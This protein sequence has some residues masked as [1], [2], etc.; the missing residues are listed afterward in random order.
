MLKLKPLLLELNNV[1]DDLS[2]KQLIDKVRKNE[3]ISWNQ[4]LQVKPISNSH[5]EWMDF[6]LL[7]TIIH[8]QYMELKVYS[9]LRKILYRV[10]CHIDFI[11]R[12]RRSAS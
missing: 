10:D 3:V 1:K 8:N 9:I 5:H 4:I 12:W 7:L 2:C 11:N 6:A